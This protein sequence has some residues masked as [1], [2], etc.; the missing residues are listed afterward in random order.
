MIYKRYF[1]LLSAAPTTNWASE[2]HTD[3]SGYKGPLMSQ[4]P[5]DLFLVGHH[6]YWPKVMKKLQYN[7][8]ADFK[9]I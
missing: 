9:K 1:L 6:L 4:N 7:I 5:I 8:F 3:K 2:Q